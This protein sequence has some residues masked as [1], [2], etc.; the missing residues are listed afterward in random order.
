MKW[1]MLVWWLTVVPN[2]DTVAE[3]AAS[4]LQEVSDAALGDNKPNFPTP[5]V[6]TSQTQDIFKQLGDKVRSCSD[7]ECLMLL[8][9][10]EEA[11]F[12][13]QRQ[14]VGNRYSSPVAKQMSTHQNAGAFVPVTWWQHTASHC[15]LVVMWTH[16]Q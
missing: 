5:D 10:S 12:T 15:P 4:M 3:Q 16:V 14:F 7:W 13:T 2:S 11:A 9:V 1:Y 6:N 8:L